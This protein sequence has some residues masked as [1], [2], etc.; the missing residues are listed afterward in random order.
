MTFVGMKEGVSGPLVG[1]LQSI[2]SK[3]GFNPGRTDCI[4]GPRTKE[5]VVR[6]QKKISVFADGRV[7]KE[8]FSALLPYLRGWFEY[9]P[10]ENEVFAEVAAKFSS[11][12]ALL[13][14][15]NPEKTD[16]KITVPL[17]YNTVPADVPYCHEILEFNLQNLVKR[18]PFV[19]LFSIGKSVLGKEIYALKIGDG[20]KEIFYNGAHH[21]NEW[22][23]SLL[24]ARFS[25]Q[26]CAAF[27]SGSSLAGENVSEILETSTL[28][29]VP[30]VNPDGVDLVTGAYGPTSAVF[31]DAKTMSDGTD[32]PKE[33]KANIVGVDLNLNY[34]AGWEDARDYKFSL[35]YTDPRAF[36][37]VG[38]YPLSEPESRAVV[39]FTQKHS[40]SL[41]IACHAQGGEIFPEYKGLSPEKTA[42]I[43]EEFSRISGYEAKKTPDEMGNAGYKDWF[44]SGFSKPGFT[45]EV[46]R[47]KNPL[48]LSQFAEIYRDTV[49]IFAAAPRLA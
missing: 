29:I 14:A 49:G 45:V 47:G 16:G 37:Y 38:R 25:E 36:G 43:A 7:G 39:A 4:F 26:L 3:I 19:S 15:A 8:T 20:E 9:S 30:C 12:T 22:I 6:F 21:A 11:P 23:T 24:L 41:V 44:I 5:A 48:P 33:W 28:Y 42:E 46:G 2:L 17:F 31:R 27:A 18:F 35:G 10:E 34:P 13:N 1:Y 32:F 40:F